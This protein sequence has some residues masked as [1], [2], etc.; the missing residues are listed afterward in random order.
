MIYGNDY[1]YIQM[2]AGCLAVDETY[3]FVLGKSC[4][5]A[6]DIHLIECGSKFDRRIPTFGSS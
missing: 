5:S 6:I 3:Q 2:Y 4:I 1:R